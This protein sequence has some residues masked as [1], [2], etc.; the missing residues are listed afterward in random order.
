MQLPIDIVAVSAG[1]NH[2]MALASDGSLWAWGSNE[3]GQLGDGTT[4]NRHAPV[5][6]LEN[7]Y[8]VYAGAMSTHAILNDGTLWAWGNNSFGNL[9]DGTTT[10]KHWPVLVMDNVTAVASYLGHAFAIRGDGSL[11]AWGDNQ[12][13][14]LGDGTNTPRHSPVHILDNVAHVST[15]G[16]AMAIKKD[17]SLW[18]WGGNAAGVLGDGVSGREM[19]YRNY[20]LQ[21]MDDVIMV[22]AGFMSSL[23]ITSEG[24]LLM[25]GH[26]R[27]SWRSE[28]EPPS[29]LLPIQV[30]E[31][32]V[33]A[34]DEIGILAI[35][36]DG[37]LW[38][39]SRFYVDEY[40]NGAL[41]SEYI[42]TLVLRDVVAVSTKGTH[43][44]A[45]GSDGSVWTWGSNDYGQLGDGTIDSRSTPEKI[46]LVD[47]N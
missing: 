4:I 17:G 22:Q 27:Y 5:R 45:L 9:G 23:A 42:Q 25:W 41:S 36:E 40:G 21:I 1:W 16:H 24:A 12:I 29:H 10:N 8:A 34:V 28:Y 39:L 6:V 43:G 14:T 19:P 35:L 3:Y 2:S 11:W 15:E 30:I 31:G 20:P 33:Y 13:G 38:D 18:T 47:E 46:N 44:I 26:N 7:V 32:V 37:N